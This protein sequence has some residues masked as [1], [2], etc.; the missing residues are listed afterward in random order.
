MY[1]VLLWQSAYHHSCGL[2]QT[3]KDA[4]SDPDLFLLAPVDAERLQRKLFAQVSHDANRVGTQICDHTM[5]L[6]NAVAHCQ[7]SSYTAM[8][9]R[10]CCALLL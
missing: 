6:R 2:N 8:F 7:S 4:E 9:S 3:G 10:C 1:E 5:L